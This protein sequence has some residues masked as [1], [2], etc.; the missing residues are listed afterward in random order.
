MIETRQEAAIHAGSRAS[1]LEDGSMVNSTVGSGVERPGTRMDVSPY[2]PEIDFTPYAMRVSTDRYYSAGY[3]EREREQLWM[4]VWQVAGRVDELPEPGDWM[5]YR[6]FDQ[7]FVLVRGKDNVIRGFVNACR[8]RGNAFCQGKG[9][10]SR[11]TCPYHNWSYGLDGQVLAVAKPAFDGPLEEFVGS[12]EELKLLEVPV[13]CFA[14]FIFLNPDQDAPPL[15]EFLGDA[16]ELLAAYHIEEMIPVGLNVRESIHCNWK[17]VMDAFYEGY[18]VHSVHPELIPLV[19]LTNERFMGLGQH[20]A[21]TVPFCA[22]DKDGMTPEG[23]VAMIRSLPL[24]NFPGL[25]DVMPRFEELVAESSDDD[26][27]LKLPQGLGGMSLLQQAVRQHLTK[28]GL[29]V[30]AL[31]DN[32]MSDYQFWAVFPN[33]YIQLRAGESTVIIARPHPDGDPNRC[34]WRVVNYM[35]VVP[36]E[37]EALRLEMVD[38][39]DGEHFPY[40]LALEQDYCQMEDQQRGLRNRTFKHMS[41]T[42]QEP[43]VAQFHQALDDW[44]SAHSDLPQAAE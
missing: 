12:K 6:I 20:G 38:I 34:Y 26:G 28:Q 21:T 22:P 36:E 27:A 33:I 17:V 9:H 29:D 42:R 2:I 19:N 18:H 8:H 3:Y 10:S 14:G 24:A 13:E 1:Y 44:M 16:Y 31:T 7:S 25:A 39:P 15:F 11:F 41:L 37:R 43:K 23:E 30:S 40:F 4:R 32:Q 5:E 35:W